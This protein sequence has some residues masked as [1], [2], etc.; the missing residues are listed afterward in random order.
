[1]HLVDDI[2]NGGSI[3]RNH[4]TGA[5]Q[6]HVGARFRLCGQ[7]QR[8]TRGNPPIGGESWN[9]GWIGVTWR[10]SDVNIATLEVRSLGGLAVV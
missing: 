6:S 1:M 4:L 10:A 7:R 5:W 3:F 9:L 8:N 2:V